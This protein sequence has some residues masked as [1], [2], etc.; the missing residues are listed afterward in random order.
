VLG[1]ASTNQVLDTDASIQL[2]LEELD[3]ALEKLDS[4]SVWVLL[5]LDLIQP[6]VCLFRGEATLL[7]LTGH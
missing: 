2:A 7:V 5:L 1:D 4:R 3:L 6:R